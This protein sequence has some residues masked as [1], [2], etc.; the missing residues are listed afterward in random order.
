MDEQNEQIEQDSMEQAEKQMKKV[1]SDAARAGKKIVGKAVKEGLKALV[2]AVGMKA[3]IIAICIVIIIIFL[4]LFLFQIKRAFFNGASEQLGSLTTTYDGTSNLDGNSQNL[5]GEA[6]GLVKIE[7]RSIVLDTELF[8]Q[9]I[10]NMLRTNAISGQALG[11]SKDYRELKAFLEAEAATLYPDLRERAVIEAETPIE[12]GQLQGCVKF[13]RN[14]DNGDRILLEYMPYDEYATELAK[15]GVKLDPEVTQ[16]TIYESGK[17]SKADVQAQYNKLKDKFTLDKNQNIVIVGLKTDETVVTYSDYAEEEKRLHSDG[18][19]YSYYFNIEEVRVNYQSV[20]QK[21]AMPFELCVAL[22]VTTD[23]PEYCMEVA[24]LAK[25]SSIVIDIQDNV[26]TNTYTTIFSHTSKYSLATDF[27][28]MKEWTETETVYS[29]S[30]TEAKRAAAEGRQAQS[31]PKTITTT[32]RSGPHYSTFYA[33]DTVDAKNYETIVETV[34]TPKPV[35]NITYADTWLAHIECEY[36]NEPIAKVETTTTSTNESIKQEIESN[37]NEKTDQTSQAWQNIQQK[38]DNPFNNPGLN[39]LGNTAQNIVNGINT[40]TG[41]EDDNDYIEHPEVYHPYLAY[42]KEDV[43]KANEKDAVEIEVNEKYT[44]EKRVSKKIEYKSEMVGNS[45]NL[46]KK[47]VK[48]TPQ[49]FLSLLRVDPNNINGKTGEKEFNLYNFRKNT[50]VKKYVDAYGTLESPADNLLNTLDFFYDLIS[51][52]S[53]TQNLQ[54][55]LEY[56][57]NLYQGKT[58]YDESRFSLYEPGNFQPISRFGFNGT[59]YGGN[60][61]EKV[62]FAVKGL[63]QELGYSDCDYAVAG[64]MGNTYVESH[65]NTNNLENSANSK[66][67]LSDD[68]FTAKV[69]SGQITKDQFLKNYAWSPYSNSAAGLYGYGLAQWTSSGRKERLYSLTVEKGISISD[70]DAQVEYLIQELRESS[71]KSWFKNWASARDVKTAAQI[72]C[73]SFEVGQWSDTRWTQ[74]EVY[75]NQYHG[76]EAPSNANGNII[77]QTAQKYVG[78]PYVWGGNSLTRGCD[79]SHFVWLI[80]KEC[81]IISQNAPYYTTKS[82]PSGITSSWGA[83]YVGTDASQAQEGDI[84]LFSNAKNGIHHTA[85]YA[86]NGLIVEAQGKSTGITNYRN[87]SHGESIYIYIE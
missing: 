6:K 69:D 78:N 54:E 74:G 22:L 38:V 15:L 42:P 59:F 37:S 70:V 87:I 49:K 28:Y 9:K 17:A 31:E 60:A 10:D 67:G 2:K 50:E 61:E 71:G 45:Y 1:G 65:F 56:L 5:T 43:V 39:G 24:N 63:L 72:Y 32:K 83:S 73:K 46:V 47:D 13:Y 25:N 19:E 51:S 36:K 3:I 86:G 53:K 27:K 80:L 30:E 12:E 26:E 57:L 84:I 82:M 7:D 79:C 20:I 85:F 75:Y 14:Y 77:V 64:A 55:T 35:F 44:K 21:Y 76:M 8:N 58:T 48:E 34:I 16:E 41:L 18:T 66:S 11:L 40:I 4:A 52:N 62:W 68:A 81:G 29:I 23:N 33:E